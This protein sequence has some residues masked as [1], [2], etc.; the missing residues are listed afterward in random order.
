MSLI[1]CARGALNVQT[2]R[3]ARAARSRLRSS[4]S[5]ACSARDDDAAAV[6]VRRTATSWTFPAASDS[7]RPP[8]KFRRR[9]RFG[10]AAPQQRGSRWAAAGRPRLADSTRERWRCADPGPSSG[11]SSSRTFFCTRPA[12][13]CACPSNLTRPAGASRAQVAP[14][15]VDCRRRERVAAARSA[16]LPPAAVGRGLRGGEGRRARLF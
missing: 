10:T 8:R 2:H 14:P 15:D 11:S 7:H 1:T 9:V 16:R 3:A 5:A 6:A 4:N 12:Y 13:A